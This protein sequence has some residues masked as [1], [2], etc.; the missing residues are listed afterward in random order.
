MAIINR[1]DIV[2][3]DAINDL[4]I[5]IAKE[6]QLLKLQKEREKVSRDL[7]KA[8]Q[9]IAKTNDGSEAQKLVQ[10]NQQ[11]IKNNQELTALDKE[12]IRLSNEK[13]KV[14]IKL[15]AANEKNA[16]AVQK[17][18]VRLQESNKA[19][20]Q[21]AR[22]SLG[23]VGAYEKLTRETNQAQRKFKD[24]A[25]QFGANSKQAHKAR[26]EF[27]KLDDKLRKVNTAAKDG[28]RDVGRYGTALKGLGQ[29][30]LGAAGVVGGVDL[31]VQGFQE[32]VQTS[33]QVND[34]TR[35]IGSNFGITGN[36]ARGLAANINAIAS[37]FDQ[38]YNEVLIA[39]NTVS[40]ELGISASDATALIEEGFLKGSNNSGEFLDILKE[41][42]V[43][44]RKAGLSA[45]QAF[46]IIN[47]QVTAGVYSD[48]GVDAIKEGAIQLT[49]WTKA[50]SSSLTPLGE[51]IKLEVQRLAAS[52]RTFE[53]MQLI[54][55]A[56]KENNLSASE[57]QAIMSTVFRGAG[58]D[59]E[60]FVLNLDNI[61][62]SLSD[63]AIQSS[64]SEQATLELSK[65]WNDF[66]ATTTKSGGIL[67]SVWAG[68]KEGIGGVLDY[69]TN[70][71]T[72]AEERTDK[73][74]EKFRTAQEAIS[75]D[76]KKFTDRLKANTETS[77]KNAIATGQ[78]VEAFTLANRAV[79][80]G[81]ITQEEA[82]R[83]LGINTI[84]KDKNI[85][86]TEKLTKAQL[87]ELEVQ[88][89][90]NAERLRREQLKQQQGE[91]PLAETIITGVQVE[92]GLD[93]VSQ[94]VDL[95]KEV[96]KNIAE[97]N[98]EFRK[99]ELEREKLFNDAKKEIAFST[100]DAIS[101]LFTQGVQ[102]DAESRINSINEQAEA[103]K[104]IL[105]QQLAD[106]QITEAEFR[107][108]SAAL[109]KKARSDSA[110]EE[111]KANLFSIAINTANA[112]VKALASGFPPVNFINA[113]IVAAQGALQA[114]L[115]AAKP[116]PSFAKGEVNIQGKRHSQGGIKAEI[117]GG[118]SVINRLGTSNAP[119]ALEAINRGLMSDKDIFG[120]SRKQS[121]NLIAG[122]LMKGNKQN[123]DMLTA[124]LNN[125]STIDLGDRVV[126][127]SAT[128]EVKT[129]IKNK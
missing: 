93:P 75:G 79:A 56:L 117:E 14:F 44:F 18:K 30:L 94:A 82:N 29:Q 33:K 122:L 110:K 36:E 124:L 23:L 26:I 96:N 22:E 99:Q 65:S 118:E 2:S 47:Q 46:A 70:Y 87:K 88:K 97:V 101:E 109:D 104:K 85:I 83:L 5:V 35:K 113:G 49:E 45:D 121:D 58:E 32:F 111:K 13:E 78:V 57:T 27:E 91:T 10:V 4:D 73:F 61:K 103:E 53:A 9:Q 76:T 12:R 72:K 59:A 107:A 105:E 38:D 68:I 89:K 8:E 67:D 63:V 43:Q 125:K 66:V 69:F 92:A 21:N 95:T 6:E 40:K 100:V 7:Q 11:L 98:A 19:L 112:I 128:G 71:L 34:L 1:G 54:S 48:K 25:A 86:A 39:A 77:I 62:T 3:K 20:K 24:L 106:G 116:I 55:K 28:R 123:S 31:L 120:L 126:V 129:I 115:V 17:G 16:L 15:L 119:M 37:T 114:A 84:E 102:S 90:L 60:S 42:P 80:K 41:Y 52:G 51:N 50:V 108:K 64:A 74:L 81:L 127:Y